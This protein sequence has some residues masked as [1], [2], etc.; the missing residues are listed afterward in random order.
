MAHDPR[1]QADPAMPRIQTGVTSFL[2]RMV[3]T[4]IVTRDHRRTM[5]GL[6]RLGI[7]PWRIFTFSPENTANQTYRGR[8]AEFVLTVCFAEVGD[9]IWELIEPVSGDTIFR[10]HLDWHGEGVHHTAHDCNN[11]P[12][13]ARL[14]E[15]ARRGFKLI[16]SGSWMGRNHFAF[17]GTEDATTT[18]F[19]TYVFPDDW[20]Y[21][22]PDSW[23]P[24]KP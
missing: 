22:E 20:A 17:F 16:Q 4:C 11:I 15:F 5:E 9:M 3:E 7:G 18:C 13:E 6:C 8:P 14:E 1:E 23:Y 24:A 2:G 10:D 12:F 21:P 19:E